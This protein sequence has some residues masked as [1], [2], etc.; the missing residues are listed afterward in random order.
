MQLEILRL[1]KGLGAT[2]ISV[3]HDQEE[4]LVMSDR[5]AIFSDGTLVQIGS[6]R[7]LYERPHTEF[8]ADFIGESNLLRGR[9]SADGGRCAVVAECWEAEMPPSFSEFRDFYT[10]SP[11]V[12]AVRPEN[13]TVRPLAA[14]NGIAPARLNACTA[15][16]RDNIYLGVE[17]RLVATLPDGAT[18]QIRSRNLK[19]MDHFARGSSVELSWNPEHAV[20]LRG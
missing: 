9:V 7:Q 6:P 5:I 18:V 16:V 19:E 2:V 4:A 20:M 8:V 1:V 11:V 14:V 12:L 17:F 3:T 15:V 13:I 10:G